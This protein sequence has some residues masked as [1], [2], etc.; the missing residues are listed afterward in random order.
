MMPSQEY[1][2]QPKAITLFEGAV[3]FILQ[4]LGLSE[5]TWRAYLRHVDAEKTRRRSE[6][7]ASRGR[8][9]VCGTVQ[10]NLESQSVRGNKITKRITVF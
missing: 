4:H 10:V 1:E 8:T 2:D 6:S 3:P 9:Q 7:N 5:G